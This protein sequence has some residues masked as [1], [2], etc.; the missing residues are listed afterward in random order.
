M[1]SPPPPL[2]TAP[3]HPCLPTLHR[4]QLAIIPTTTIDRSIDRSIDGIVHRTAQLVL[5]LVLATPAGGDADVAAARNVARSLVLTAGAALV[6]MAAGAALV[7]APLRV[8]G[9]FFDDERDGSNDDDD[10]D[11][12]GVVGPAR[13]E[14]D[15]AGAQHD[16]SDKDGGDSSA[17][18]ARAAAPSRAAAAEEADGDGGGDGGWLGAPLR[19]GIGRLWG[20]ASLAPAV[21]QA[22]RRR[23]GVATL[24]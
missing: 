13:A 23:G 10:D 7:L 14:T 20:L 9:L 22:R 1:R 12:D 18:S 15:R 17:S 4:V 24:K 3:T 11:D 2:R 6:A 5:V 16:H 21:G 19:A 8:A